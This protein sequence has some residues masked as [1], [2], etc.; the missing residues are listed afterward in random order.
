MTTPEPRLKTLDPA[1][2]LAI[3]H[4]ATAR[5]R[6]STARASSTEDTV[7]IRFMSRRVA[8]HAAAALRLVGYQVSRIDGTDRKHLLVSGWSPAAL[9]TR[10]ATMRTVIH[11]LDEQ[12]AVTAAAVIDRTRHLS[13]R[14]TVPTDTTVL[15]EAGRQ[16]RRWVAA[17][18]GIHAPHDPAILPTDLGNR[19]R[20]RLAWQQE[21][22]ID[23]LIER[24][25]KVAKHALF[26]F[27]SLRGYM[28][29]DQAQAMAARR[30]DVT[31]RLHYSRVEGVP[32]EGT[33]TAPLPGFELRFSW[34]DPDAGPAR[35][36]ASG[37]PRPTPD[38]CRGDKIRPSSTCPGGRHFPAGRLGP[39]R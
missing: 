13:G 2:V 22:T 38:A 35:L 34:P 24:H 33:N 25:L 11:Q 32:T 21:S 27:G 10:L 28:T 1:H 3:T 19:L 8:R 12:P 18:S 7:R 30:A 20:L 31:F 23:D 4:Q 29:D 26:L 39:R 17:R 9:E 37:F 16:L 36:A 14:P 6:G 5:L 15:D